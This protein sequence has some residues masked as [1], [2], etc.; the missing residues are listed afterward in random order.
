MNYASPFQISEQAA[1][2]ELEIILIVLLM[3]IFV[4]K[5]SHFA[6]AVLEAE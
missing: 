5:Y 6:F 1:M 3:H 2:V 4:P